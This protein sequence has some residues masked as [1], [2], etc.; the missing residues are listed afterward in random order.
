MALSE[1]KRRVIDLYLSGRSKTE[2]MLGAGYAQGTAE[3][4][5]S[6]IFTD[7]EVKK[8]IARRMNIA[9]ARA[10]ITL[11]WIVD[12]LKSIADANLGDLIEIDEAGRPTVNYKN[13]SPD[14]KRALANFTVDEISEGRG[15][16]ARKGLRIRVG[17]LDKIRA[18]EL[19]V[20]HLGLSKEKV[21]V[22]VEADLVERLQRGRSRVAGLAESDE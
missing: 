18:L 9:A 14:L 19:L 7:P 21:V 20:K 16:D 11:D 5:Q 8:E 4:R 6:F 12:R 2:A 10:D 13:L 22:S 17:T 15:E 1:R 3:T